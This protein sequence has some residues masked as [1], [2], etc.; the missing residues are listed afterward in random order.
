[1]T[2][3]QGYSKKRRTRKKNAYALFLRSIY[4]RDTRKKVLKRDN[5]TCTKCGCKK[6]LQVHHLSYEHHGNEHLFLEDLTTLCKKC[7]EFEHKLIKLLNLSRK[8]K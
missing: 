7:H 2:P 6:N 5:Y 1:M 8:L 4:W 3:K